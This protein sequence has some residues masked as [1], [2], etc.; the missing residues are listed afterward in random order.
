MN[1]SSIFRG[2]PPL[3]LKYII[4]GFLLWW[5]LVLRPRMAFTLY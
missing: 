1:N 2:L 5:F 4:L 3:F